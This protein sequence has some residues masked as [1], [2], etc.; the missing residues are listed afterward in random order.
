MQKLRP[1]KVDVS[2]TP[3]GACKP[4]GF[5]SSE[6]RVLDLLMLK[7]PLEPHC[8][9]HLLVNASICHISSER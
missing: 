3:I 4:Y 9:N 6:V 7:T 8:N 2:T 1:R 5:S